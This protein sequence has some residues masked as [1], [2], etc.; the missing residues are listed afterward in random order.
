MYFNLNWDIKKL[1]RIRN[2]V[3]IVFCIR[4]IGVHGWLFATILMLCVNVYETSFDVTSS[5]LSVKLQMIFVEIENRQWNHCCICFVNY[6]MF[7]N[8]KCR[9]LLVFSSWRE[10]STQ[11]VFVVM[12]VEGSILY[13]KMA[14]PMNRRYRLMVWGCVFVI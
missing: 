5:K 8:N 10:L 12:N 6:F 3:C 4:L 2:R 11:L 13:T 9:N 7:N 1:L 14:A